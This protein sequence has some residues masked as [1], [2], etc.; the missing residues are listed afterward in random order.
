MVALSVFH[1]ST[2]RGTVRIENDDPAVEVI[3]DKDGPT[4]KGADKEPITLRAG[5]HGVRIRRGD[6]AFETDRLVFTKGSALLLKVELLEDKGKVQVLQDGRGA[7]TQILP[8]GAKVL[9]EAWLKKVRAL[10]PEEQDKQVSAR[11]KDLNPGFD[12]QIIRRIE[13]LGVRLELVTDQVT[14]FT[15]L[16]AST[17]ISVLSCAGSDWGKGH[18][19]DPATLQSMQLIG[20]NCPYTNV[21]DLAPLGGM[22]LI[23]LDCSHTAVAD[24]GPLCGMPMEFLY[25]QECPGIKS[26]A[27]LEGMP[28]KHFHCAGT[29]IADLVPLRGMKLERLW[30][31]GTPVS[32]LAP[33]RGMPLKTVD[34]RVTPVED[35]APLQGMELTVLHCRR[36]RVTDLSVLR[37]MPLKYLSCEFRA[38]RDAALLRSIKTLEKINGMPTAEFWKEVDAGHEVP[39]P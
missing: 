34:I 38:E 7:V 29:R 4:I 26:L 21:V 8:L 32:D 39:N 11:L 10:S 25:C 27:S 5:E 36:T 20:L 24:L 28:L 37:R 9:D 6:F 22:K 30:I 14:N 31:T 18:V 16:R 19:P 12:G 15:P 33:L 1:W 17:G 2:P 35:L 3:F 13:D 23:H